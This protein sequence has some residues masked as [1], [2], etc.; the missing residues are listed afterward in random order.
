VHKTQA[1]TE[2]STQPSRFG[3]RKYTAIIGISLISALVLLFLVSTVF[4]T[5][6]TPDSAGQTIAADSAAADSVPVLDS[7]VV[8]EMPE[9]WLQARALTSGNAGWGQDITAPFDTLWHIRSNGGREFFS[10]P[11][12]SGGTLYFGCND[13]RLRSV[14]AASGSLNW[15]F[16]TDCGI[17][18]E[19]AV[20]SESVY[21]GGQDGVVYA[22]DR[23]SG[24]KRWSAGLGYHV[25]CDIGILSDT[26]IVTGNSM[27]KVCAL[28]SRTGE[29]VW[30]DEI[31]G[32]V[33]G[34]VIIDSMAVF[35][36]ESGA[37]AA[38]NSSGDQVWSTEYS[39]QASPPSADTTGVYVGFSN[40]FVRKLSLVDGHVIWETDVVSSTSRCVMARPVIVRGTVL[41]GTNDGQL[42]SLTTSGGNVNW[43]QEF[44]NWIQLPPVVGQ[45]L[46]YVSC[47]DQRLHIVEFASG[48][49]ADSLEMDGYS[50]TAPLLLNGT[51]FFGNTSG[52]FFALSGTIPR[53][54]L[55]E[56]PEEP[57]EQSPDPDEQPEEPEELE[58]QFPDPDEQ[59]EEP[60]EQ[61]E[62]NTDEPADDE[63]ILDGMIQAL[64]EETD[65]TET[66]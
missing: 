59:P 66:E 5:T 35:S 57:E 19:P 28:D 45:E 24:S 1:H 62:E 51:I 43:R 20:D 17:C 42:V 33:L 44:D 63:L 16:S 48:A 14:N 22:L 6:E 9:F 30:D 26:L 18:G 15:S 56:L 31:G 27:G 54:E 60:E 41:S 29:P 3:D 64:P 13:G 47:D 55:I 25:F 12:Y 53:D 4:N 21:F 23:S 52:D 34:P 46:I 49:K 10:S 32:I 36:T 39:S 65:N 40:G 11:A 58:E 2:V 38:F 8:E 50:G 7:I 37:V 61:P